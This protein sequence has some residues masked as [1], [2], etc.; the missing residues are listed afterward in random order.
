[1][2]LMW[3]MPARPTTP[4]L[5]HCSSIGWPEL[6]CTMQPGACSSRYEDTEFT[7]NPTLPSGRPASAAGWSAHIAENG[8]CWAGQLTDV[9]QL[10]RES[11]LDAGNGNI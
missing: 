3:K 5:A 9:M 11:L 1:M 4:A 10:R 2:S 8:R 6:R 7:G